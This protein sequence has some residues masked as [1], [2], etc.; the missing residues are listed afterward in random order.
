MNVSQ[1]GLHIL[2]ITHN[3]R[4]QWSFIDKILDEIEKSASDSTVSNIQ[5]AMKKFVTF[6]CQKR[7]YSHYKT[8]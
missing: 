6:T 4:F 5:K 8:F 1:Y 7:S 3:N 2:A